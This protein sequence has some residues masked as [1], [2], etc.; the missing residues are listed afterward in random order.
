[1][2]N[3]S[4]NTRS[5]HSPSPIYGDGSL[6]MNTL[7][8][9]VGL[10]RPGFNVGDLEHQYAGSILVYGTYNMPA[11]STITAGTAVE[12]FDPTYANSLTP[13]S[14]T[15]GSINQTNTA[16]TSGTDV[17][18]GAR[19]VK[20]SIHVT[21]TGNITFTAV[22]D[23]DGTTQVFNT[24]ALSAGSYEFFLGGW[25]SPTS[26]SDA[27]YLASQYGP[28]KPG[29][30]ISANDPTGDEELGAQRDPKA[31]SNYVGGTYNP[32]DFTSLDGYGLTFKSTPK[33]GSCSWD[34]SVTP[35]S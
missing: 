6:R 27:T 16:D 30:T 4:K 24:G 33:V 28:V 14:K 2:A 35:I 19:A 5:P 8:K 29:G 18:P 34:L 21:G 32:V 7:A 12:P 20:I 15:M 25:A 1:M 31:F 10:L 26:N 3:L 22:T 13:S 9:N 23:A 11:T 17:K